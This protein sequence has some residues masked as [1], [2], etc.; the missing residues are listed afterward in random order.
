L[1]IYAVLVPFVIF[2]SVA[3]SQISKGTQNLNAT[4][5]ASLLSKYGWLAGVAAMVGLVYLVISFWI[6]TTGVK[7]VADVIKGSQTGVSAAFRYGWQK[8]WGMFLVNFLTGIITFGG[9]MIVFAL[10]GILA[11]LFPTN[12]FNLTVSPVLIA[13]SIVRIL[14]ILGSLVSFVYV[15]IFI[16]WLSFSRFVFIDKELGVVA[17]LRMSRELVRGRF[18]AVLWRI[19]VLG[20]FVGLISGVVSSIPYGAGSVIAALA[21]ALF[22]LPFFLLY[23]ELEVTRVTN[24]L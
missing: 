8:T 9:F 19:S 5:A 18:W 6:N 22:I 12:M 2:F 14:L 16:V 3:S 11:I 21:G 17:S 10:W 24:V 4:N 13:V 20:I 15:F 7:I 1:K 23:K